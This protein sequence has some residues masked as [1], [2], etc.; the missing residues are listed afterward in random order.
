MAV[1]SSLVAVESQIGNL[2][3]N[4]AYIQI[5]SLVNIKFLKN[6]KISPSLSNENNFK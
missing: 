2:I 1:T 5:W 6:V 4:P 3:S